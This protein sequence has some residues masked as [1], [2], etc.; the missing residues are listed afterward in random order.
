M[1][2][3]DVKKLAK[4][5]RIDRSAINHDRILSAAKKALQDAPP[6]TRRFTN[7][8]FAKLAIAAGLIIAAIMT[9]A[10]LLNRPEPENRQTAQPN[11]EQIELDNQAKQLL[12][13]LEKVNALYAANDIAGLTEMLETAQYAAKT[14]AAN[15]LAKIGDRTAIPALQNL[16][17]QW[18]GD[19]DDNPFAKAIDSITER[20]EPK[21][22]PIHPVPDNTPAPG[23]TQNTPK[24][25]DP[26]TLTDIHFQQVA[27]HQDGKVEIE[28]EF[29]FKKPNYWRS[30]V[31]QK[32][33]TIDNGSKKLILDQKKM[34]AQIADSTGSSP[35][36][37]K[38]EMFG[39]IK[40]GLS[41]I[42]GKD[43]REGNEA[44]FHGD[45]KIE[46]H[47]VTEKSTA[48]IK[49]FV[50]EISKREQQIEF[51]IDAQTGLVQ[52][53]WQLTG[54]DSGTEFAFDY[55]QIPLDVFSLDIPE[56][57]EELAD[58]LPPKFQGWIFDQDLNPVPN[59]DI[60]LSGRDS[61]SH[62]KGK[63][64]SKGRFNFNIPIGDRGADKAMDYPVFVRA[65]SK[66][67]PDQVAWTLIMHPDNKD[68]LPALIPAPGDIIAEAEGG[69]PFGKCLSLNNVTL[70]M[71]PAV[72]ITG[73]VLDNTDKKPIANA[74]VSL[75][76]SIWGQ[77]HGPLF[78]SLPGP[79]QDGKLRAKTDAGGF[80]IFESVPTFAW[81]QNSVEQAIEDAKTKNPVHY[82]VDFGVNVNADGYLSNSNRIK[83][84]PEDILTDKQFNVSLYRA[85]VTVRGRVTDNYGKPLVG[86]PVYHGRK[87]GKNSSHYTDNNIRTNENGE[88]EL[89][90]CAYDKNL[91]VRVNTYQKLPG[92]DKAELTKD[93]KFVYYSEKTISIPF[94]EGV[95]EYDLEIIVEKPELEIIF[96][97]RDTSGTPIEGVP[98]QIRWPGGSISPEWAKFLKG[99]TDNTG[100]CIIKSLPKIKALAF[101]VETRFSSKPANEKERLLREKLSQYK[102]LS[103]QVNELPPDDEGYI[104][105]V[106][107]PKKDEKFNHN[108]RVKAYN[109]KS[110]ELKTEY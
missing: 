12:A 17:D 68:E 47:Q 61:W 108:K 93:K 73:Q 2:N 72:A 85:D 109:S 16:S 46:Y 96:D 54:P 9:A 23:Q 30:H 64:D 27:H 81:P 99:T 21:P 92:W 94:K 53:M 7:N 18:T 31:Q 48:D 88:F 56:G 100:K 8:N 84:K 107:M 78:D 82:D 83:L 39:I 59:A 22:T 110:E 3:N 26:N 58:R 105:E 34:T 37:S 67:Y 60:Y 69:E 101:T 65:T 74:T 57:Y 98:V 90:G 38:T 89:T 62:A 70:V 45:E 79:G 6:V 44:I 35:D 104:I 24:Y 15:I 86:Y 102:Y 80:Y 19:P 106:I 51:S 36:Y 1:N 75:R 20:T 11:K 63:S 4:A 76:A 33:V 66:D 49:V 28:E 42:S 50:L 55:S 41:L 103:Y 10:V 5:I 52:T 71:E 97:V 40:L 32:K 25:T 77:R 29:W 95:Y 87:S 14:A 91:S 13:Q 43:P